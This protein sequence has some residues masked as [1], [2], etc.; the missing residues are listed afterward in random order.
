MRSAIAAWFA[1]SA[2]ALPAS[3]EDAVDAAY[4]AKSIASS[5]ALSGPPGAK[6]FVPA[7]EILRFEFS[8][9]HGAGRMFDPLRP[10]AACEITKNDVC[11]DMQQRRP[12]YRGVR[13]YMPTVEGLRPE[14]VSLKREGIVL[15]YSFK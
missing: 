1:F 12:V 8:G 5:A 11:F 2:I 15:K 4:T 14:S 7:S 13:Q 3:A 6:L 10:R 9:E